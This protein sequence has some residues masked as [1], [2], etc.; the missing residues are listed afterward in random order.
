MVTAQ[1]AN[2]E[3]IINILLVKFTVIFSLLKKVIQEPKSD[4]STSI[5]LSLNQ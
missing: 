2:L 4:F 5:F 1:P 3:N